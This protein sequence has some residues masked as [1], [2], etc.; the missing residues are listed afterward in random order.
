MAEP[1]LG[2]ALDE[3]SMTYAQSEQD[4]TGVAG[5]ERGMGGCDIGRRIRPHAQDARRDDDPAS[6][7]KAIVGDLEEL[8][9]PPSRHPHRP[10][11]ECLELGYGLTPLGWIPTAELAGPDPDAAECDG[12]R[13][14][15][16]VT[17]ARVGMRAAPAALSGSIGR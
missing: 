14:S 16:R 13:R 9:P 4:S 12:H 1:L 7:R 3:V 15:V 5:R 11:A 8:W 6:G 17:A 10:V 2:L